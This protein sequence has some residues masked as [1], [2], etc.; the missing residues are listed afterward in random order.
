MVLQKQRATLK[1]LSCV[2]LMAAAGCSSARTEHAGID[3][4]AIV[5]GEFDTEHTNVF[6]L[7]T[8]EGQAVGACSSTLIAPNLL[9]TARHCVSMDVTREVVCGQSELGDT[10]PPTDIF[11][12]NDAQLGADS[13][14][15]RTSEVHVPTEGDDTC[16]YDVAL[17]VLSELVPMATA[18]SA[19]PRIDRDV[20]LGEIYEAVGYGLADTGNFGARRMRDGLQVACEPGRCG[21]SVRGGEFR[22]EAGVCEGD[23]GGPAFD[24]EGKVVG[25]V[26]RG[27][28][29]CSTPVYSTVTAWR[30]LIVEVAEHAATLGGYEAPFWV[31]S[32]SSDPPPPVP[33]PVVKSRVGEACQAASDCADGNACYQP[34]AASEP[35]FCVA[36]CAEDADC[37]ADMAC[38]VVDASGAKA[39]LPRID[40]GAKEGPQPSCALLGGSPSNGA[41]GPVTALALA[42]ALARRWKGRHGAPAHRPR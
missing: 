24:A 4:Q 11:A 18:T 21:G 34:A 12:T 22:G 37:R 6:G 27:G 13:N 1:V 16:G 29:D 2:L 41:A 14:W 19:V 10:H 36:L 38:A 3:R 9:L 30:D 35:S 15:F 39:C 32:G 7:I 5:G 42:L 20:E 31:K 8:Q 25:V 33:P 23:S 17:V 28:E 40:A 26:S